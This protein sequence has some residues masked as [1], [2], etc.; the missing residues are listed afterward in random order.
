MTEKTGKAY[1]KVSTQVWRD[2]KFRALSGLPC[3]GQSLWL[4]L[5]AGP[6]TSTIPGFIDAIPDAIAVAMRWGIEDTIA[7][8]D[9]IIAQGMAEVDA[10][11]GFIW[12]PAAVRHN[13]CNGPNQAKTWARAAQFFPECD[14]LDRAICQ[15]HKDIRSH[16]DA[17]ADAFADAYRDAIGHAIPDAIPDG[18]SDAAPIQKQKQKQKEESDASHHLS[19]PADGQVEL[20]PGSDVTNPPPA[21]VAL[22]ADTIESWTAARKSAGLEDAWPNAGKLRAK[23]VGNLR[24]RRA[25]Y[26]SDQEFGAAL[27]DRLNRMAASKHYRGASGWVPS[28]PW[29]LEPSGWEKAGSLAPPNHRPTPKRSRE[30][31]I[32]RLAREMGL[33]EWNGTGTDCPR[34]RAAD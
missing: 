21:P 13:P 27:V 32:D 23:S 17:N 34:L 2:R 33:E 14:L 6:V 18:V 12:L 19:A 9:E 7:A 31:G 3:S 20:D 4:V 8:L 25:E 16:S 30:S 28:L 15:L 10:E 22:V 24:A 26:A 5:I 29:L 11:A 1:R